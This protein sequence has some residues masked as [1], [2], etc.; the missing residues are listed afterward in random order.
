MSKNV[1]VD[2]QLAAEA[3]AATT[4]NERTL[5]E[6]P[7][8]VNAKSESRR[9]P[10]FA[11]VANVDHLRAVTA[12]FPMSVQVGV[13]WE[14][15]AADG[16][17]KLSQCLDRMCYCLMPFQ[18]RAIAEPHITLAAV[19]L[20]RVR[21][22]HL[23]NRIRIHVS[24]TGIGVAGMICRLLRWNIRMMVLHVQAEVTLLVESSAADQTR[25][26][27]NAEMLEYVN[28]KMAAHVKS[29]LAEWTSVR[30]VVFVAAPMRLH[31]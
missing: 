13:T 18:L 8:T 29:F 1:R 11:D 19:V 20:D 4:A 7:K 9:K 15:M 25:M 17:R 6:V 26:W 10:V 23:S 22:V 30:P 14:S 28:V 3:S 21:S 16:A 31:F 24:R 5:A 2:P 27:L 12:L